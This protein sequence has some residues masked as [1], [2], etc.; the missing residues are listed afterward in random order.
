[1]INGV[2]HSE[3]IQKEHLR[4]KLDFAIEKTELIGKVVDEVRFL[5]TK[6][7]YFGLDFHKIDNFASYL[8]AELLN[9]DTVYQVTHND[10]EKL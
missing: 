9:A 3:P 8:S 5:L 4:A 2:D 6:A 7:R 1:M 10:F